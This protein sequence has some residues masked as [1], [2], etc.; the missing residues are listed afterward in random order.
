VAFDG[1]V[2]EGLLAYHRLLGVQDGASRS[3]RPGAGGTLEVSELELLDAAGR[4][5]N[6]FRPGEALRVRIGFTCPEPAE[7][8]VVAL[9]VRDERGE[10]C[11]RTDAAVGTVREVGETSFAVERLNLLGGDYDIAVGAS[12]QDAPTGAWLDRVTR[13]SVAPAAGGEGIADLRGLWTVGDSAGRVV[14]AGETPA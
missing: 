14:A 8:V 3:V 2:A 9:E 7:R 4:P 1:G 12:E 11:F 13:L 10:T 6:V 5:R